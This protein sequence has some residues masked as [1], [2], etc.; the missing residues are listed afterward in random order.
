MEEKSN[1]PST[2]RTRSAAGIVLIAF[3]A[4]VF[5]V[6]LALVIRASRSDDAN[7]ATT[8]S[9]EVYVV[10]LG[11]RLRAE[12]NTRAEILATLPRGT[13]LTLLEM[14]GAWAQ[15][16]LADGRTGWTDRNALE[17]AADRERRMQTA[18]AIR[19]LPPLEGKLVTDAQLYAGPG[20]F[21]PV[22]GE[23]DQGGEVRVFTRD[24]EFYAVELGD[25]IAYA[26]VQAVELS[27]TGDYSFDV[28]ATDT[29]QQDEI[30][31][32]PEM[33]E[34]PS[35][36]PPGTAEGTAPSFEDELRERTPEPSRPAVSR[37]IYPSVPAGG[38]PPELVRRDAPDYPIAARRAGIEGAV[39]LRAVINRDG[40]VGDVDIVKDLPLGLGEA[41]ARSVKRW[42]FR[43]ATL[44]G[45]PIAVYYTITVNYRLQ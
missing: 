39:I 41:A 11:L 26:D 42:R 45:A 38:S 27:D 37:R 40:T 25:G 14:E 12:P 35:A 6:L 9:S 32:E 8:E 13:K 21:Y 29:G 36:E 19:Q 3:L 43:P 24:H 1:V 4:V 31:G 34:D 16:R 5:I 20:L 10:P 7:P 17:S 23:M 33:P 44:D 15:V 28:A 22:I 18:Q 30:P 2:A